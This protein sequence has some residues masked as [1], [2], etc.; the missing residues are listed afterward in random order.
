MTQ[1]SFR[2]DFS[3]VEQWIV[4]A[5]AIHAAAVFGAVLIA[6]TAAMM[7]Y[8]DPYRFEPIA[9]ISLF[10][11]VPGALGLLGAYFFRDPFAPAYVVG[12]M[13]ALRLAA[14]L[15]LVALPIT[16]GGPVASTLA[17]V[18]LAGLLAGL[19]AEGML[20]LRPPGP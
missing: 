7:W 11:A 17:L 13:F 8:N 12:M 3:P 9:W 5:E 2:P 14:L 4:R 19:S 1:R 15:V 6:W 10:C 16:D 20:I 18:L